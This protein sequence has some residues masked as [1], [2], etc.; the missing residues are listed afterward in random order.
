[1]NVLESFRYFEGLAMSQAYKDEKA[2]TAITA[3]ILGNLKEVA[4]DNVDV[5]PGE[6]HDG[7]PALFVTVNLKA[8]QKRISGSRL[9]D[10]IVAAVNALGEIDDLRFPY[11]TFLAPDY[12][13]AEDTRPAA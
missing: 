8:G 2:E 12:E 11:M 9:L 3:A 1:M 5:R 6:N 7:E 4:I 10:A 13:H